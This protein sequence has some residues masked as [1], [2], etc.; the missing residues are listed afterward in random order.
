M[1]YTAFPLMIAAMLG[2]MFFHAG[3]SMRR[4]RVKT[5]RAERRTRWLSAAPAGR[6]A[7]FVFLAKPQA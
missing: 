7:E 4:D 5:Q 1:L 2:Y 6:S 3:V